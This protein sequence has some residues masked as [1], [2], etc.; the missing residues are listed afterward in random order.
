M[1]PKDAVVSSDDAPELKRD[2]WIQAYTPAENWLENID[3]SVRLHREEAPDLD[4]VTHEVIRHRLWMINEAH[5]ATTTRISG[6]PV[7]VHAL[8]FN[9]SI[10]SE[11]AEIIYNAPYIQHM[12]S[13]SPLAIKWIL[14]NLSDSP[15]ITEGDMFLC[16]DPWIGTC[17]Q[18]DV[19]IVCPVFWEGEVFAWVGNT[20]HQYD[21]GGT[22]PGSWVQDAVDIYSDPVPLPPFKLVE[23][24]VMRKDLERMFLRHSRMPKLVALD[25]RSQIAGCNF[26]RDGIL[27]LIE[28][29]GASIVKAS[30]KKIISDAQRAFINKLRKIPDGTWNEEY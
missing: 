14:E 10:L 15:G 7:I 17:H 25:L 11:D 3:P 28:Q 29:Y 24:G 8:D 23:G 20:A 18:P 26:A 2:G 1:E 13:A 21:I 6:S 19:T 16:N 4:P 22:T 30:M 5:G 12:N 9:M 27:G